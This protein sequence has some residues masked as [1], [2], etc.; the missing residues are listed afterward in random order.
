M[1]ISDT[2]R[3][4]MENIK[5]KTPVAQN[6]ITMCTKCKMQLE[7]VVLFHNMEGII[8][9]IKCLTYGIL[10]LGFLALVAIEHFKRTDFHPPR[11]AV[12]QSP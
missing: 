11:L 4:T 5:D 7:H 9:R 8:E 6:L 1:K 10:F 12:V 3:G 2:G